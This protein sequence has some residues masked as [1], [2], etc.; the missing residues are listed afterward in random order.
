[1]LVDNDSASNEHDFQES[2]YPP[3]RQL[4][5]KVQ[6]FSI[7]TNTKRTTLLEIPQQDQRLM[8]LYPTDVTLG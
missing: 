5:L 2:G 3:D 6:N 4:N 1:M 7:F 8:I